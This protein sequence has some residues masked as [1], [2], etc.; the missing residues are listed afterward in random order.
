MAVDGSGVEMTRLPDLNGLALTCK[1]SEAVKLYNE[2]LELACSRNGSF[3]KQLSRAIELDP[4]FVLAICL[5]V[6]T[7]WFN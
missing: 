2:A 6:S 3:M 4:D 1:D 5:K 7:L